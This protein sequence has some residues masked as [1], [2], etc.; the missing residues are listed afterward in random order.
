M[1]IFMSI[2]HPDSVGKVRKILLFW[3]VFHASASDC[4]KLTLDT[5]P[6]IKWKR[7]LY[8]AQ[9]FIYSRRSCE[10]PGNA[11]YRGSDFPSLCTCFGGC[12]IHP[13]RNA[14]DYRKSNGDRRIKMQFFKSQQFH[15]LSSYLES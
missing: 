13:S 4:T 15:F 6:E 12:F 2:P 14:D 9:T 8:E 7:I 3:T 5:V 11:S 10:L 1:R